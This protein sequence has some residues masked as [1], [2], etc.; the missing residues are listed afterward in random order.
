M[1]RFIAAFF[2][3]F[4]S[5][6]AQEPEIRKTH[7]VLV[8]EKDSYARFEI[9]NKPLRI[10][11]DTARLYHWYL[12]NALHTSKGGYEGLLLHGDYSSFYPGDAL[13][14]KGRF[15]YG[16]K[17][18]AW[19][20][21]HPNGL[22]KET[23]TWKRGSREGKFEVKNENGQLVKMYEYKANLLDGLYVEYEDNRPLLTR[24]FRKN[25]EILPKVKVPREKKVKEKK[26]KEPVPPVSEPLAPAR[27]KDSWLKRTWGSTKAFVNRIFKP[28]QKDKNIDNKAREKDFKPAAK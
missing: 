5:A 4:N 10:A 23:G 2:L 28:S 16:L 14:E 19:K 12:S 17:D 15:Y 24:K 11:A 8:N 27:K 26:V 22:L 13:R 7:S 6:F 9:L 21:W 20:S 18:G 25:R 1:K 3:L